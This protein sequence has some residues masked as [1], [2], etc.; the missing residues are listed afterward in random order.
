MNKKII[1][2]LAIVVLLLVGG[3]AGFMIWNKTKTDAPG[4]SGTKTNTK[5]K[6][7]FDAAAT[8][9]WW[10][11]GNR[12]PDPK[13]TTDN[14]LRVS[15]PPIASITIHQCKPTE[16]QCTKETIGGDCFVTAIYRNTVIDAEQAIAET[17]QQTESLGSMTIQKIG[18]KTL[19][20]STPE[21]NKAY[22]LHLYDYQS[23]GLPMLHGNA[24]GYIPLANGH[25]EIQSVC[26]EASDLDTTLPVLNAIRL[27]S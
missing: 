7:V 4:T 14:Q 21:G 22:Q 2:I 17:L 10:T 1:V 24:I 13:E 8:P 9:G 19:T 3:A 15:D 27:E 12:W 16:S 18:T 25:V 20:I 11:G 23:S 6:F 5:P 26:A